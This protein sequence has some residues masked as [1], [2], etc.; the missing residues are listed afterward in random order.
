MLDYAVG[1]I[2]GD[3]GYRYPFAL[4]IR[5]VNIIGTGSSYTNQLNLGGIRQVGRT[6][7]HFVG[8]NNLAIPN[9]L[10]CLF[11]SCSFIDYDFPKL[12]KS[13]QISILTQSFGIKNTYLRQIISLLSTY[14]ILI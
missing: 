10:R 5:Q 1:R 13:T 11:G 9:S 6:K 4:G 12:L 14:D 8:D 3:V 7:N 2:A